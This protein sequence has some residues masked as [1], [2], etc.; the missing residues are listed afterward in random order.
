MNLLYS[1]SSQDTITQALRKGKCE[2]EIFFFLHLISLVFCSKPIW[3][4]LNKLC[5]MN[6]GF[7]FESTYSFQN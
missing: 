2:C 1:K 5:I 4:L 7:L 3:L 6:Q